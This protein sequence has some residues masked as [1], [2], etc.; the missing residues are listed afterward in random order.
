MAYLTTSKLIFPLKAYRVNGAS[1]GKRTTHKGVYWGRHLGE[2]CHVPTGTD[3]R[4][5]GRGQ[6]VY[7]AV[8]EGSPEKGNWG[9]IVI[10]RHKHPKTKKVFCSLYAHLATPF[11]RIGEKVEMGE[12][13]GFIGEGMTPENGYWPS[14]LHFAI[15]T[16]P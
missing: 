9:N 13:L 8:H 3:V 7:A 11:K 15:Y 2:D 16:G 5:A 10:I 6:V 14:H 12:P 4:A 1:F